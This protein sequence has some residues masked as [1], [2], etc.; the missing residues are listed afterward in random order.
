MKTKPFRSMAKLTAVIAGILVLASCGGSG[1]EPE[2]RTIIDSTGAEVV[3]PQ[4][5]S[6]VI[7][8]TQNAMEFMVAMGQESRLIGVHKSVFNHTWSPEYI[9]EL[10][11]LTGFGYAPSAEAVYESGA[12]L[13]I[14]RDSATAEDLRAAGIL[15]V[16]FN[17]Q[18][19]E[20]LFA[21]VNMLGEIFGEDA[22]AYAQKWTSYY[23]EVEV[24]LVETLSQLPD[25]ERKTAYFID[26]STAMDAGSL[27]S[28]A[29][30]DSI[31]ATWFDAVGA[32]LVTRDYRGVST[33]NEEAVLQ[34]DPQVILIGGWA[35]NT[36]LEQLYADP[37]WADVTAVKEGQ[38]YLVPDGFGSCVRYAVEAPLL[39]RYTAA[40]L[41]PELFDCDPVPDFQAFFQEFHQIDV[42]AEKVGYMLGGLSPDGSRMD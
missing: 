42:P 26:A 19:R 39:L 30:G 38:V 31:I 20:E 1:G 21:A 8:V 5:V 6:K 7:C 28:T 34:L 27:C 10:D 22:M 25:K 32:D 18:N 29:G 3:L 16:T 33:I 36:R 40:Q 12:D 17:Y 4:E 11:R 15:A 35:E 41:Y 23:E 37:K 13:V 24:E 9:K 14:V 2:T